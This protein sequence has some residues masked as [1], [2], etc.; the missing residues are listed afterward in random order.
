MKQQRILPCGL[1]LMVCFGLLALTAAKAQPA[2][3]GGLKLIGQY[4]VPYN[5]NYQGTTV[6][7][8]SGIDYDSA[9]KCYY[10]ISDDRSAINPARF[11]TANIATSAKGID[12]VIFTKVTS[13]T[14]QNGSTYPNSKQNAAHTPDPEALRYNPLTGKII[15]SSEGERIVKKGDTVLENPAVTVAAIS[16]KYIDTLPLPALLHMKAT[17]NGPRQNGVFEG[18]AYADNY[19]T[20]FVSVE[21]PLYEDGPRAGIKDTVTW[22]RILKYDAITKKLKAAYAYHLEPV[23]YAPILP[24]A[25]IINGIPDILYAG[26][27]KLLVMERS[28][29]T[30]RMACTIRIYTTDVSK[31]A[32]IADN[33]SLKQTPPAKPLQK[34]LLL[35]M[36]DL[37]IY[38]DNVEGMTFGPVL[39]NGH[40]TLVMVADNNFSIMEKTQFFLFEVLP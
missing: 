38:V 18:L 13:F 3:I 6:G 17:E 7:G 37:G 10:L 25:F 5:F 14:Q 33:I 39:P 21:E 11:Y 15:W 28:F 22:A 20:L 32:N 29:S 9:K 1:F 8:L 40:K 4:V 27:N 31:A 26:N 30:G 2:S 23:A 19:K 12:T 36:D 35:N 34:H 16:G 24:N